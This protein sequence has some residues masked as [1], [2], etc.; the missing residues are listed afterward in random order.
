M[1]LHLLGKKSWN[2]YNADNIARVRRDE[3]DHAAR[4]AAEEQRLEEE[5]AARRLRILRGQSVSPVRSLKAEDAKRDETRLGRHEDGGKPRKRRRI[6]GE[7]DTEREL[8]YAQEDLSEKLSRDGARTLKRRSVD[9][10]LLDAKGNINLFPM[11]PPTRTSKNAEAEAEKKRK[12]REFEDQYTMRF[13]NAAG[14]KE[15]AGEKPWYNTLDWKAEAAEEP[16]GKDVWG[17][18]DPGRKDRGQKRLVA[19][20]PLALM[21]MGVAGVRKVEKERKQWQADKQKEIDELDEEAR[22]ERRRR[23]HRDRDRVHVH[24]HDR[25]EE[26]HQHRH[27]NRGTH[28][29]RDDELNRRHRTSER[30]HSSKSRG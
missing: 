1:P 29:C 4:E 30:R 23:K 26:G 25:H 6:H 19:D 2:V 27:R 20:D 8:R 24:R 10:P 28:R 11:A 17:R 9:A 3:A 16:I 21:T 13:C 5:D 22:I 15:N 18:E 7:D 12:E 14:S